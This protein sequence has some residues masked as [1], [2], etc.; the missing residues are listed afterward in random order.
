MCI[1]RL[2]ETE[3]LELNHTY[4]QFAA[5]YNEFFFLILQILTETFNK[6]LLL[7]FAKRMYSCG[8][9][10]KLKDKSLTFGLNWNYIKNYNSVFKMTKIKSAA[11]H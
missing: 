2:V 10:K 9:H 7:F 6:L 4:N 11:T 8:E 3:Y 5:Q 1:N